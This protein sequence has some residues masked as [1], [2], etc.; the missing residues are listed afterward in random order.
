MRIDVSIPGARVETPKR[1]Q[2]RQ[3]SYLTLVKN[4][5]TTAMEGKAGRASKTT[6]ARPGPQRTKKYASDRTQVTAGPPRTNT[7]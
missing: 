1:D 3:G 5:L 4:G 6:T 7:A 2:V